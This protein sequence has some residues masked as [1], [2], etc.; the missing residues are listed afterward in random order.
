MTVTAAS[1]PFVVYGNPPSTGTENPNQYNPDNGPGFEFAMSGQ[2]DTQWGYFPGQ[3]PSRPVY[4]W[5]G[6]TLLTIDY[7]PQTLSTTNIA[8]AQAP[9]AATAMTL[10]TT[11][12]AGLAV[13]QTLTS[14]GSGN[15]ITGLLAID[16]PSVPVTFGSNAG[17]QSYDPRTCFGRAVAMTGNAGST[18]QNFTVNGY[19]Y[20]YNP[21][22][23][24]IAF[25]GGAV[26][27]NGKKAFKYIYSVVST[28]A[29]AGHLVSVGTTD[30][31]GFPV[32][33]DDF[34]NLDM[35]WNGSWTTSSGTGTFA[36][37]DNTN[38]Q[39]ATTGDVRGT[40]AA[41]TASNGTKVWGLY[42]TIYP[43]Q[44]P[45]SN[46]VTLGKISLNG[47]TTAPS[48]V[49]TFTSVPS[50]VAVGQTVY[51]TTQT[52]S[53]SPGSTITATTATTVTINSAS[54]VTTGAADSIQFGGLSP[55]VGVL[56]QA[57]FFT[58]SGAFG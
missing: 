54:L 7:A 13:S 12:V 17:I 34:Q 11:S 33:C 3:P 23:E 52:Y 1:G 39:T 27:T 48:K 45:G 46:T 51:D 26:T 49:L 14:R 41:N 40:W 16:G 38:P 25:A 47:A 20:M 53:L 43:N 22:T 18:A 15:V 50:W 24:I 2:L 9:V 31:F 55:T 58:A 6:G 44:F 36:F 28:S 56:G 42:Q 21:M 29:D 10:A 57:Q 4:G 37:A 8:A 5:T 35:A 32:R 30:I 19:D